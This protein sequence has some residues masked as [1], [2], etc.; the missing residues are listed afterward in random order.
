MLL[1]LTIMNFS[2]II[3]TEK[4]DTY[5]KELDDYP[6]MHLNFLIKN[7]SFLLIYTYSAV[8]MR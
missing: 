7:L 2:S 5:V 8:E 4:K 3:L 6:R 1:S